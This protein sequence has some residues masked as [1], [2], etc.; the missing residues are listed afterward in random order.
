[1][2]YFWNCSGGS[3]DSVLWTNIYGRNKRWWHRFTII[4]L[5]RIGRKWNT[6]KWW[7]LHRFHPK[8]RYHII[9]TGLKPGYYDEDQLILNACFAMLE[10]YIEW[11]GG[12]EELQKFSDELMAEPDKNAPPGARLKL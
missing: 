5:Y 6:A 12:D 1:M 2:S 7:L 9:N 10:R 4:P 3:D 8:Y 11:H